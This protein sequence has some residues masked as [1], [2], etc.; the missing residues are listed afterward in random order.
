MDLLA[1]LLDGKT[2]DEA[3]A[4]ARKRAPAAGEE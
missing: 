2:A 1:G 4:A 3:A